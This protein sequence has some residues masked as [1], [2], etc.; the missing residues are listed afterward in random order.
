MGCLNLRRCRPKPTA[1]VLRDAT[2]TE[3]DALKKFGRSYE[4]ALEQQDLLHYFWPVFA[5]QK[6]N[7]NG[8]NVGNPKGARDVG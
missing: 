5:Q 3:G 4:S 6:V 7:A 2:I 8:R 1:S